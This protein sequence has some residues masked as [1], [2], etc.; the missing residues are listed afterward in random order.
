MDNGLRYVL[1]QRM[2]KVE[3]FGR[4]KWFAKKVVQSFAMLLDL[5]PIVY[6]FPVLGELKRRQAA[7]PKVPAQ[8]RW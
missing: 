4:I 3:E 8:Y 5:K 2:H 7:R 6:C 1:L